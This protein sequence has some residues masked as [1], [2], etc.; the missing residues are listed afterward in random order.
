MEDNM[1][2]KWMKAWFLFSAVF[3][4]GTFSIYAQVSIT[5]SNSATSGNSILKP[6]TEVTVTGRIVGNDQP[7]VG[8]ANATINLT[9]YDSYE[10]T[11]NAQGQF[12]INGVNASQTYQYSAHADGYQNATGQAVVGTTDL[13]MGDITVDETVNGT[14]GVVAAVNATSTQVDLTWQAPGQDDIYYINEGFEGTA[15]PPPGW[16]QVITQTGI[17][18][19]YDVPETWCSIGTVIGI[20]PHGGALQAGLWW[21]YSHQNEWLKTPLFV[22][23]PGASLHFWSRVYLGSTNGDHYYIKISTDNGNTWTQLW[24]ASA[25][26]GG[27]N[28]Y[29]TPI[30]IDLNNYYGQEIKLAWHADSPYNDGLS[31]FWFIDDITIESPTGVMSMNTSE[32]ISESKVN[33]T[34][35]L[36][37]PN[38]PTSRDAV[39][40]EKLQ[41]PV[42][43]VQNPRNVNRTL[44]GYKVWR[45][46]AGQENNETSWNQ[47][48][49]N[50]ITDLTLTDTEWSYQGPGL[51]RWV[52]KA[53][54]TTAVSIAV[55]SNSIQQ[56]NQSSI[57]GIITNQ[58]SLP[59]NGA[60]VSIGNYQTVTNDA[61]FYSM[62]LYPGIYTIDASATGY[63]PCHL[64]NIVVTNQQATLLNIGSVSKVG[65]N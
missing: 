54:Y 50:L 65:V 30:V 60:L 40:S 20:I 25:L 33:V 49:A 13:N 63:N 28:Y 57:I 31:Y 22:C 48:T 39:N 27:W 55:F 9:G 35:V 43:S 32:L 11:T 16:T 3:I 59:I 53:Y 7:T 47:L 51:Y 29:S 46:Q 23:P 61:G 64:T 37:T 45:V 34:D 14:F 62:F 58:D 8:L 1:N 19:L 5:T 38:L 18:D 42:L 10:A 2:T 17:N 26:T 56:N 24:D 52:V 15:F 6:L 36:I 12:T 41:E 21:S 4:I 44:L